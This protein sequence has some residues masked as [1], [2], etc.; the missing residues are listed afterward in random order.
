MLAF[1]NQFQIATRD[2][3]MSVQRGVIAAYAELRGRRGIFEAPYSGDVYFV[4]AITNN[5]GAGG[6][7]IDDA[8]GRAARHHRQGAAATT[9]TD[10]WINYAVPIRRH[11]RGAEQGRQEGHGRATS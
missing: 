8:Q 3:P 7:A 10:T 6:G 1:S 9:L 2:E 11:R 4:D 5:P